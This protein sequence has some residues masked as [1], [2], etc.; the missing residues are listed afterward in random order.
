MK[1]SIRG[2]VTWHSGARTFNST[3]H[4]LHGQRT[5]AIREGTTA[6]SKVSQTLCYA[7]PLA[8]RTRAV[9]VCV[10]LLP[11]GFQVLSRGPILLALFRP[12][13][14]ARLASC[15]CMHIHAWSAPSLS[16]A[17]GSTTSLPP[18]CTVSVP[19]SPSSRREKSKSAHSRRG[20]ARSAA[21]PRRRHRLRR[22]SHASLD[23][24]SDLL[25]SSR[26]TAAGYTS[27]AR[28]CR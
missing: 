17:A 23:A 22:R 11:L 16:A 26:N 25:L 27:S 21:R 13:P 12:R 9:E 2:S 20:R 7:E 15:T 18:W 28:E 3:I 5:R 24:A 1:S 10:A 19:T 14:R 8:S 4:D 6:T